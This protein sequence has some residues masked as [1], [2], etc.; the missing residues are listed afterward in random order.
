MLSEIR[1]KLNVC[2]VVREPIP[3]EYFAQQPIFSWNGNLVP[4]SCSF[5]W[6]DVHPSVPFR[7]LFSQEARN[8]LSIARL[9]SHYRESRKY[10]ADSMGRSHTVSCYS[11]VSGMVNHSGRYV[12]DDMGLYGVVIA[13]DDAKARIFKMKSVEEKDAAQKCVDWLQVNNVWVNVHRTN[14]EQLRNELEKSRPTPSNAATHDDVVNKQCQNSLLK[15]ESKTCSNAIERALAQ[16]HEERKQ[17]IDIMGNKHDAEPAQL[18][19]LDTQQ[20]T[21]P[22][23]SEGLGHDDVAIAIADVSQYKGQYVHLHVAF[24]SVR[25]E[26][27]K[28]LASLKGYEVTE[29]WDA[30]ARDVISTLDAFMKVTFL[31]V[32]LDAKVFT[33]LHPHGT[34]SFDSTPDC[35]DFRS[36]LQSKIHSL[37]DG[38]RND[39]LW[40]F[41][42]EE[43]KL[44]VNL[45][46]TCRTKR[47]LES[48]VETSQRLSNSGTKPH[49][50]DSNL[51]SRRR[52]GQRPRPSDAQLGSD[53]QRAYIA[54]KF[55][56]E[57]TIVRRKF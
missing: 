55:G 28:T 12:A 38:C 57:V 24:T 19:R 8:L 30:T 1:K 43:R 23:A 2:E 53:R 26:F 47:S 42:Q 29:T 6:Q 40:C 7:D 20:Q 13:R 33:R 46:R 37:D 44:K 49:T 35:V 34:G 3:K 41:Y 48:E 51:R 14:L 4:N 18:R 21:N 10:T 16:V 32:N 27:A 17:H 31:D 45:H 9:Y 39:R 5:L 56:H 50:A 22:L 36:Y 54:D 15:E 11:H 52:I 25:T